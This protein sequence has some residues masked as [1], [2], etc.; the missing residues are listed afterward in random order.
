MGDPFT[1]KD[2]LLLALISGDSYG[3]E[4][5][6]R[7]RKRSFG[8]VKLHQGNTYA[9]LRSLEREGFL[10]S[11]EGEGTPGRGGRP[12]RYYRLTDKGLETARR[13]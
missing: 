1:V 6:E 8:K 11:Y 13:L 4:L 7:V 10:E 9:A 12:R 3:L 5:M 2:A